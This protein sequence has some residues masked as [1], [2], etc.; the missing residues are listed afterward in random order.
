MEFTMI[1][2]N[3]KFIVE[4]ETLTEAERDAKIINPDAVAVE[5]KKETTIENEMVL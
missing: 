1:V 4:A 5:P 3:K 2:N